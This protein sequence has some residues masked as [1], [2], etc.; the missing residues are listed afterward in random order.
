MDRSKILYGQQST[1]K[2]DEDKN[3]W[4]VSSTLDK[5]PFAVLCLTQ[6]NKIHSLV[7]TKRINGFDMSSC[8]FTRYVHQTRSMALKGAQG[9][10]NTCTCIALNETCFGERAW[11][12]H[13]DLGFIWETFVALLRICVLY[14]YMRERGDYI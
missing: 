7:I 1:S 10:C 3:Y 4:N 9:I 8:V 11:P 13:E 5:K 2:L 12:C 6:F 14:L